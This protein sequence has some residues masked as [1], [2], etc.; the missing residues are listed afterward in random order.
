M[1][2]EFLLSGSNQYDEDGFEDTWDDLTEAMQKINPDGEWRC[3][4]TGFG[5]RGISGYREFT[6]NNGSELLAAI[7][8]NTDCSFKIYLDVWPAGGGQL[9]I[10]NSHHDK[11][12]GGEWYTLYHKPEEVNDEN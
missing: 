1:A 10:D 9:R 8:P 7:L 4:L 11:P 5:W 3:D 6:T 2:E 12:M